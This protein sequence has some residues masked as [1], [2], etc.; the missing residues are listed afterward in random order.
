MS[1][2]MRLN[3]KGIARIVADNVTRATGYEL[4]RLQTHRGVN[5]YYDIGRLK[6]AKSDE[7]SIMFDVG[8]NVGR[9]TDAWLSWFPCSTVFA[10]EPIPATFNKLADR[11]RASNSVN[12]RKLAL[13]SREECVLMT[14]LPEEVSGQNR[15]L[16]NGAGVENVLSV[17]QSTLDVLCRTDNVDYIDLLK[18]DCEGYDLEVLRGAEKLLV[19]ERIGAVYCEVDFLTG[20][21]HASFVEIDMFLRDF[22]F[23]CYGFYDYSGTG[24]SLSHSFCNALWVPKYKYT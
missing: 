9:F 24:Y 2:N 3:I 7:K 19:G 11:F 15:I 18:T 23:V 8:A 1:K 13:G 17:S 20:G 10:V 6:I 4:I 12:V 22:G 14:N 21:G 16:K 5:L